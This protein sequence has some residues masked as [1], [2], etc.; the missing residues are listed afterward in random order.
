MYIY[1]GLGIYIKVVFD[2][3]DDADDD[4]TLSKWAVVEV[5]R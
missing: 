3:N 5:R 1:I 4:N 2:D